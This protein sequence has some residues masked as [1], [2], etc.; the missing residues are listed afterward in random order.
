MG[1]ERASMELGIMP[2]EL[3]DSGT[4]VLLSKLAQSS[5]EINLILA[6]GG[7]HRRGADGG[8]GILTQSPQPGTRLQVRSGR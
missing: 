5:T 4:G 7:P 2:G 3:A 6:S 1:R 8:G